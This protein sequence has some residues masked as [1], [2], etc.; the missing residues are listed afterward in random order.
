MHKNR[1]RL[2]PELE[3]MAAQWGPLYRLEMADKMER[4]IRQLRVS[5]RI[6]LKD[7]FWKKPKSVLK[8]LPRRKLLLN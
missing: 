8:P 2:E 4:W 3:R 7:R 6:T 1:V 5:A